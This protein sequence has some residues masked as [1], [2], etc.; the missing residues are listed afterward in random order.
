MK[1][2]FKTLIVLYLIVGMVPTFQSID[3]VATQWLYLNV[4]NT[5]SLFF[6]FLKDY[7]VKKY[8]FDKSTILFFC[9]FFWSVISMFF[10]INS[11]ESVVVLSQLLALVIGFVILMICI[12]NIDNAFN[13]ISN[14]ISLYLIIELSMI[15]LPF[16]YDINLKTIFSRSF[17][18]LGFAA[19]INITAFSILYK[20]PFFVYT[21]LHLKT[22]NK[23]LLFII[24]PTIFFFTIFASGTLN[25]TR[26]A[27]LT[28]SLLAPIFFIVGF[29]VYLKSKQ[30]KL[31]I[32]STIYILVLTLSFPVNSFLSDYLGKS[33]SNINNRMSSLNA[34]IDQE[35]KKDGS[36][37]QR[38]NFYSQAVNVILKNP[39]SG[40]GLGN[41]KLKSID[42]DK[43]NIV[44]YSVPYHVH[45]DY[46][47]IGAEIGLIGLGL[48]ITILFISFKKV[49]LNSIEIIF[50]KNKLKDD[51]LIWI[52]MLIFIF[53]FTI[54]S[55]INF[56]FHRPIV[57]INLIALL[58]YLN[59]KKQ[60]EIDE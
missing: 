54:D 39:F 30:I 33:E 40:V 10:A 34:L 19:N 6:L 18:F 5:F 3:K 38:I 45:N 57:V 51:F 32:V 44:G 15:Y 7:P 12:S 35:Q 56:P 59:S 4:L 58:A 48:Y 13:F 37:T 43:K 9:L 11:V 55:N 42:T 46:L 24:S 2:I 52:T 20:L 29:V 53:I 17:K 36:L 27:I 60:E 14:I 16:L 21:I 26:G 41:W 28:Y 1:N 31:L 8:F 25:S 23:F 47:E 50:T 22:L 49:I